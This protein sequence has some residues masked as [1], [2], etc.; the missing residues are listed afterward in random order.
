MSFKNILVNKGEINTV[1]E[2]KGQC[3]HCQR[4]NLHNPVTCEAFPQGIPLA[5]ITGFYDHT[6]SYKEGDL[7]D[8]G[9]LFVPRN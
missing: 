3:S 1:E 7:D 8:H 9:L 5:I 2:R 4:Q 6:V